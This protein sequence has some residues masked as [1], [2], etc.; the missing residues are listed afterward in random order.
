MSAALENGVKLAGV[1]VMTM[2]YGGEQAGRYVDAHGQRARPACD[3][4]AAER[5]LSPRRADA[6]REP[7]VGTHRRHAD[8][9]AE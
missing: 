4:Q 5:H 7:G 8:D 1:N 6:D 3:L 2:D 9:R